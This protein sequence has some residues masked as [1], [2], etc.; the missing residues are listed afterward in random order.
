MTPDLRSGAPRR[1]SE[2]LGGV[3]WLPRL[4]DKA[5]AA[6]AG[7][8]GDYLFGQSP[9]DRDLLNRLGLR[10]RDFFAI[11]AV[12]EDDAAVL[13]ALEA[14]PAALERARAWSERIPRTHWLFLAM[15]DIDDGY[16]GGA[17]RALKRPANLLSGA[18]TRTVKRLRPVRVR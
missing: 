18:F 16:A 11:V 2:E 10:H 3:R 6:R 5:R 8:L 14:R 13:R 12:A 9:M 1:W 15:I 17:L 4:I 7:T